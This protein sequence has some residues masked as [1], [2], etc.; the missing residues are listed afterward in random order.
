MPLTPALKDAEPSGSLYILGQP[1]LCSK[2][3][4]KQVLF[5]RKKPVSQTHTKKR[6]VII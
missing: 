1:G 2:F 6:K 4:D 5:H 3:Q